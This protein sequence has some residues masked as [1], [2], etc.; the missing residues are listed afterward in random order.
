MLALF[1]VFNIASSEFLSPSPAS[2]DQTQLSALSNT[3]LTQAVGQNCGNT[4]IFHVYE[5][6]VSPWPPGPGNAGTITM[7]GKFLEGAYVQEM[8]LGICYN[9]MIWNY[10]PE[11]VDKSWSAGE[12]ATFEMAVVFPTKSGSYVNNFQLTAGDHICCWQ[13][14]YNIT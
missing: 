2:N 4:N 14:A 8:V 13:F 9:S 1:I 11:V 10:Y 6:D 7:N 12:K 5:V 3:T